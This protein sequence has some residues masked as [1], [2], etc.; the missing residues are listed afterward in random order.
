MPALPT[1]ASGPKKSNLSPS[2]F[3]SLSL[4]VLRSHCLYYSFSLLLSRYF[5]VFLSLSLP[6]TPSPFSL[7]RSSSFFYLLLT[8]SLSDFRSWSFSLSLLIPPYSL[9]RSCSFYY[10]LPTLSLSLSLTLSLSLSLS[11]SGF[12]N[13]V[14]DYSMDTKVR[15]KRASK[16]KTLCKK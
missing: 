4:S 3:L 12:S 7:L 5:S 10:L 9:L 2:F 13:C 16:A 1:V 15:I 6:L 14:R 11:M 8:L